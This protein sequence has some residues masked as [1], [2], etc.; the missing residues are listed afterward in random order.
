MHTMTLERIPAIVSRDV[1]WYGHPAT[2]TPCT[3]AH[4]SPRSPQPHQPQ[5]T[6]HTHPFT[7][8][9]AATRKAPASAKSK[10][11]EQQLRTRCRFR[12]VVRRGDLT[13]PHPHLSPS[14]ASPPRCP[15]AW[16]R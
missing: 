7:S 1:M 5:A 15:A 14:T 12:R 4:L 16:P 9:S 8:N 13:H 6:P 2:P 11:V 3:P 10:S